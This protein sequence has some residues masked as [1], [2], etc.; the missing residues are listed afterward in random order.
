MWSVAPTDR[1]LEAAERAAPMENPMRR[2]ILLTLAALGLMVCGLGSTGLFAALSDV[3]R[4]GTNS[5]DSAPIAGSADLQ[6]AT[7]DRMFDQCG[8]FS[9]DLETGLLTATD[10]APAG[11]GTGFFCI[12]NVGSRAVDLT[13]LAEDLVDVDDACTGDEADYG[14]STCGSGAGELSGALD[15]QFVSDCCNPC[16]AAFTTTTGL[17]S[18]VDTATALAPLDPG[19]VTCYDVRAT[20][21]SGTPT[22]AV[23]IAQSDS[24]T[25]RFRFDGVAQP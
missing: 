22:T 8:T 23:Q 20:L 4:T 10:V 5:I 7:Y 6:L 9:D 21:G 25:W 16:T 11:G 3:A 24:V 17:A 2:S 14:D 19:Q 12:Q 15:I 1:L 13:V 18:L